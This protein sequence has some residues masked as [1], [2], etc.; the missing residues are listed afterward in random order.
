MAQVG[1]SAPTLMSASRTLRLHE[2]QVDPGAEVGERAEPAALLAR[3]DDRFDG[4][5]ADVLDR[6]QAEA[7]GVAGR[8]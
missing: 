1:S 8:P 3:G 6:E 4:A 2:A 7:D 5:L